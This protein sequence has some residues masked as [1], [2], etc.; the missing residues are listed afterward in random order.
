MSS[1]ELRESIYGQFG[2]KATA[3]LIGIW[4]GNNRGER[5]ETTFD[6]I[7]E[8][9]QQRQVELPV[10]D[11]VVLEGSV[12]PR[13]AA[14]M[15]FAQILFSFE[16]RIGR[17]TYWLGALLLIV[18]AAIG[19]ILEGAAGS[20][21]PAL[22]IIWRLGLLWPNL[23]LTVKRWHDRDKSGWWILICLIP[24]IG[25]LWAFIENG[26]LKGT[27]GPNRFGSRAF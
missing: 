16:E 6:V 4:Q 1:D 12:P 11:E 26:F 7:R 9:L 25:Q 5:S 22:G 27:E 15:S 23:A 21:G 14:A 18:L 17:Q 10:Q 13:E 19:G 3:E 20:D 2:Q 8:I 24:F